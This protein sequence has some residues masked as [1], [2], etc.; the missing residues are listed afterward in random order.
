[1]RTLAL[2]LAALAACAEPGDDAPA[3]VVGTIQIEEAD[4]DPTLAVASIYA[5]FTEPDQPDRYDDGTCRVY[6][7][8]CLGQVGACGSP[9]QHSA[10][11]LTITGLA[12]PI[13]LVPDGET[14]SYPSPGGLPADLFAD[15]ATI[16][17]SASGGAV[18]GFSATLTGVTPL[19]SP[20]AGASAGVVPGQPH[21]LTWDA[22]S[23]GARIRFQLNWANICHAGAEWYVLVCEVPDTG[24]FTIPAAATM[25]LPAAGFGPCG[26]GL[27]RVRHAA[28]PGRAIDVTVASADYFGFF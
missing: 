18:P 28:L 3:D 14:H 1:M 23:D 16:A 10:G 27:A 21:A 24:S 26:G 17:V 7:R 19:V 22:A 20:Y 5:T 6:P 25:A 11:T 8:P 4:L 12:R 13:T 2:M 9:P 15:A